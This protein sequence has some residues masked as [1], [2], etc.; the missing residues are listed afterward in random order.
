[1]TSTHE[2]GGASHRGIKLL[3][4]ENPLPPLDE[5]IAA[6]A[7]ELPHSNYYTEPYSA[8]LRAFIAGQLGVPESLV[9]INAGSELILRQIF[10]RLGRQ[11]HLLTPTYV[12]F[13]EIAQAWTETRLVPETNF[14]FDLAELTIPPGTTLTVIVN[15]NN[16]DGGTFD[17][18]P[19]PDLLRRHPETFFLVDEAFIG[20]GGESVVHRVP[21]FANLIVTRTLSKAHSLA[22][23]RVGY[24]IL[25]QPLADEFNTGNDAYPLARA[26]QAA[27][28][29]TL[30]HEARIAER[31]A[32]LRQWA[33]ELAAALNALGVKTFPS[34][35]YFFLADFAPLDAGDLAA[36]LKVH[37]ILIKPLGDPR[38]GRGFMRV[39][40]ALPE[41]NARFIEVLRGLL[42]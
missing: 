21:D 16:P 34:E 10:Q 32:I 33:T 9:H 29:A 30:Q 31:A 6:A 11:V 41:D 17:M 22:G 36:R 23:F 8:P 39:T 27:A 20:M 7:V 42:P 28:L 38:L 1:M 26:S 2:K 3:L 37:D 19:L 18:T 35:T 4:C 13:P 24:A 40:T 14:R 5:A 15:P 25:P 12:L